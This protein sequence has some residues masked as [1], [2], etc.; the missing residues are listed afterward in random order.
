MRFGVKLGPFWVSTSTRR[1]RRRSQSPR[2]AEGFHGTIRDEY[3]SEQ[4]C[5]HNHR[6]LEAAQECG[7]RLSSRERYRTDAE[8]LR[9]NRLAAMSAEEY[10]QHLMDNDPEWA[11]QVRASEAAIEADAD[12]ALQKMKDERGAS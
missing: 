1:R 9:D 12:A 10:R 4:P 8:F 3:G 7:R 2:Q 5:H 6:T 11:A